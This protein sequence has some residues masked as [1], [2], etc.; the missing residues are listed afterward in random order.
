[1]SSGPLDVR[2]KRRRGRRLQIK[3]CDVQAR[4]GCRRSHVACVPRAAAR[5]AHR[6]SSAG[7]PRPTAA[8]RAS[9]RVDACRVRRLRRSG[10][11]AP[12]SGQRRARASRMPREER[13][14]AELERAASAR[15]A[16]STRRA[17]LW[18]ARAAARQ[19]RWAAACCRRAENG[20]RKSSG[21]TRRNACTRAI[22]RSRGFRQR[23]GPHGSGCQG[24]APIA[25]GVVAFWVEDLLQGIRGAPSVRDAPIGSQDTHD[26]I[27]STCDRQQSVLSFA[28]PCA[29][30]NFRRI[31]R[32]AGDIELARIVE[33]VEAEELR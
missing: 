8:R 32:V 2:S 1:V 24:R 27:A 33:D 5:Q 19:C 11:C 3:L 14:M 21:A 4:T 16:R 7:C 31:R 17:R 13:R 6:P 12:C 9:V 23:A 30:R 22:G 25:G 20:E 29:L 26:G 15:L 18:A 10:R 28:A